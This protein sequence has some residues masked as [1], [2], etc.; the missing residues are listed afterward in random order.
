MQQTTPSWGVRYQ[1]PL[2]FALAYAL[3]WIVWGSVIAQQHHL[4]AF[5]IPANLAFFGV[6]AA[7]FIVAGLTGG[8]AAM[9][10]LVRRMLRWRVSVRWYLVALALPIVL[11]LLA[12]GIFRLFGGTVQLSSAVSPVAAA[13]YLAFQTAF[14]LITEETAWRG[15]ALPRLQARYSALTASVILG[16]LW[17]IWHTP[18]FLTAGSAQASYPYVGFILFA[19]AQS[20]LFTWIYNNS[21]GSVLVAAIFH[22]LTDGFLVFTGAVTSGP[23]LFWLAAGIAAIAAVAVIVVAGPRQLS[24]APRP[25]PAAP[26]PAA[27]IAIERARV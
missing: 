19:I 18:L 16:A 8:V 25:T 9:R 6:G 15:F 3:S 22:A 27:E 17:G 10:D 20:V 5:H 21:G 23:A 1:I 14:F 7:A 24:R 11:P 12:V 26:A 2:F 13:G 4:L